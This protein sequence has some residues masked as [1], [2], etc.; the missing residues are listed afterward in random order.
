MKEKQL[1]AKIKKLWEDFE[2]VIKPLERELA[3]LENKEFVGK[4]YLV[5]DEHEWQP[6]KFIHVKSYSHYTKEG[7]CYYNCVVV[8]GERT[9]SKE[10]LH[11]YNL[12]EECSKE[13]F[14]NHF[15]RVLNKI[16]E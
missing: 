10:L 12:G 2:S 16:I 9:I 14:D 7:Y 5:Y 8:E 6:V 4:Y 15:T 1:K 13:E 3:E 11:Q